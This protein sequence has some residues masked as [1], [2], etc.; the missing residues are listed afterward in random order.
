MDPAQ[1]M[2]HCS[3]TLAVANGETVLPRVLLGRILG[4]LFKPGFVGETAFRRNGPTARELVVA[5]QRHFDTEKERLLQ[6]VRAF[7]AGGESHCTTHPHPFFGKL[8][9]SEWGIV[10]FKHLDHHLRQFGA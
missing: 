8:A 9:P 1:M 5:D 10:M 4:P 6:L 3:A 7:S 2:A